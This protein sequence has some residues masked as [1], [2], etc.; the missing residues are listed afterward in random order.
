MHGRFLWALVFSLITYSARSQKT[1]AGADIPSPEEFV[2]AVYSTVVDSTFGNYYLVVGT[3]SCRFLKYNYDEWIKYHLKEPLPF[4]I[5]NELS[6]KVYLSTRF[7][8]YWKQPHLD[9]AVCITRKQA[10]SILA[11]NPP[12]A[13]Q[14]SSKNIVYSFSLP[15]FTDNGEFAVID[16][17]IICGQVCGTGYTCIFRLS[18]A[19]EWKLVGRYTNWSS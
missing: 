9:K 15:Q 8:Y 6:E 16:M 5:L 19:G 1:S 17:N 4:A 12:F 11:L 14:P 10:D 13:H 18:N 7:P 2:N 3:D